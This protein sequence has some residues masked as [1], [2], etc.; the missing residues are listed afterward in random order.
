VARRRASKSLSSSRVSFISRLFRALAPCI[1]PLRV[2]NEVHLFSFTR[3][4]TGYQVRVGPPQRD[5]DADPPLRCGLT[6]QE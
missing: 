6:R 3:F 4:L 2:L 5:T 1:G